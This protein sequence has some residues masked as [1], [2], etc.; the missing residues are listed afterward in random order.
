VSKF[1]PQYRRLL[2][3]DRK[4]REN[5]YPNCSSLSEEWEVSAKTFQRDIDYLRDELNAPIDYD[6][7]KHGYYYTE[8]NFSL[9]AMNISESDLFAI[10]IAE[11]TLRP[12]RNTPLHKSL[13]NVFAKI[14]DSL[15]EKT[16]TNPAWFHERIL[17]FPEPATVI[18]PK[19]W[20]TIA[21]ALRDNR[22]LLIT[23]VSPDGGKKTE[24]TVDPY[25]LVSFKGEWYLN[26]FC[27]ERGA[28]RTF[29]V[30]RIPDLKLL[31]DTFDFPKE[32]TRDK[33]FG[34][35]MG[36]IW[37][38]DFYKVRIR[39]SETVAP[40]IRERQ[41]HPKQELKELKSGELDLIFTT[42]HIMEVKDWVM[43]WGP[44]ARVMEPAKLVDKIKADLAA[45]LQQY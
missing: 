33:V 14:Q 37:K 3:L 24:R 15:P 45:T 13:S 31:K 1:K 23:H 8:P 18:N 30:S 16:S 22:R 32:M 7:Q 2:F 39:F 20:E 5:S 35:Q 42:N 27:H 29:A 38:K 17:V 41:W 43:S 9:P 4:L 10:C 19:T 40:Y 36:I 25:Y 11:N 34:D 12:F 28:V 21:K 26:T 44:Q 6:S